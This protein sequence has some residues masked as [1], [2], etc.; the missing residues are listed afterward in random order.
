MLQSEK[1][2]TTKAA[3]EYR[4]HLAKLIHGEESKLVKEEEE[5]VASVTKAAAQDLDSMISSL[6]TST[7]KTSGE[8]TRVTTHAEGSNDGI[9]AQS[10]ET[11]TVF[12]SAPVAIGTLNVSAAV[13]DG[14]A[15]A[16]G[17]ATADAALGSS[18]SHTAQ[19]AAVGGLSGG[20]S[21]ASRHAELVELEAGDS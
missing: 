6:S 9:A 4:R 7:L 2:Y 1:K 14:D 13:G 11:A 8:A 20:S 17:S 18:S 5:R 3:A 10:N 19:G 21:A 15:S 16:A 12:R